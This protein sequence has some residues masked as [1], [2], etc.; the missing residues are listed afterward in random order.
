MSITAK[1]IAGAAIVALVGC[2][3]TRERAVRD[4]VDEAEHVLL[5]TQESPVAA[6]HFRAETSGGAT[7]AQYVQSKLDEPLGENDPAFAME[8]ASQPFCVVFREDDN[9]V[10]IEGYGASTEAPTVTKTVTVRPSDQ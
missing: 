1:L 7:I 6:M 10:T 9:I 8:R 3:D 5:R 2:G 4:R